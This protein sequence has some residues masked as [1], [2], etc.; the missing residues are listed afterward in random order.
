VLVSVVERDAPALGT[1][2]ILGAVLLDPLSRALGQA[3]VHEV[4]THQA[5]ATDLEENHHSSWAK[6]LGVPAGRAAWTLTA[7]KR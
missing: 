7:V 2:S 6:R 3:G 5:T 1:T 4:D